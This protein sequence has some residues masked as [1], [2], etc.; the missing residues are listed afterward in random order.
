M[1]RLAALTPPEANSI[2]GKRPTV[3]SLVPPIGR[4]SSVRAEYRREI[5]LLMI[6]KGIDNTRGQGMARPPAEVFSTVPRAYD[7]ALK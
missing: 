2:T 4:T 3:G 7:L 6:V 5:A 1:H